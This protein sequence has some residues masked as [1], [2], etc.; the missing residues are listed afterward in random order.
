MMQWIYSGE[1]FREGEIDRD[2]WTSVEDGII[3][4]IENHDRHWKPSDGEIIASEPDGFLMPG[5]IDT[6]VHLVHDG[7][8]GSDWEYDPVTVKPGE[9]ALRALDNAKKHLLHGITT[10]RDCGSRDLADI[11][12]RDA[13]ES[14]RFTGPRIM[15][16]GHAITSTGGHMDPRRYIRPGIPYETTAYMGIVADSIGDARSAVKRCI[17]EGSDCIK[18]NVSISEPVRHLLGQQA[19]EMPLDVIKE[20]ISIAHQNMRRVTGHSHGGLA[21]D[22]A[23]EAGI[24]SLEHGRF[25]TDEQFANMANKNIFLTPTLSPDIRPSKNLVK[26][27][28]ADAAWS[29]RAMEKMNTAVNKAVS[30]GV[31]VTAG[32]DAGMACVPH[33]DIAYEVGFL[34]QAGLSNIKAIQSATEYAS[35]NLGLSHITGTLKEGLYA[36]MILLPKNPIKNIEILKD[37]EKFIMIMKEG[38]IIRRLNS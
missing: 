7:I 17:M 24:D 19:P 34:S 13:I 21:V 14:G 36:D 1:A 15:A 5:M 38:S 23:I 28:P 3:H 31:T 16:C 11:C 22:H 37:W 4:S 18:I 35:A 20:I 6:H 9:L 10:V 25:L 12:V 32:S 29:E 30:H 33:G 2:V 8:L 26:R 27:K